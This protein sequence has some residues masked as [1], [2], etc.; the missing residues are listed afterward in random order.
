MRVRPLPSK[1]TRSQWR[2]RADYLEKDGWFQWPDCKASPVYWRKPSVCRPSCVNN[3][4]LA[5]ALR[6]DF[7]KPLKSNLV[8]LIILM[9]SS[10]PIQYLVTLT[11]TSRF[12]EPH[13]YLLYLIR[14]HTMNQM[15]ALLGRFVGIVMMISSRPTQNFVT[16]TLTLYFSDHALILTIACFYS[17]CNQ[18]VLH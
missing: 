18:Y 16:L 17:F 15:Y 4:P 12:S 8:S 1:K 2:P 9:S 6:L 11:L 13:W 10:R 3:L 7:Q 14:F 5:V